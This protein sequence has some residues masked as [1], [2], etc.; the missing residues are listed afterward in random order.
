MNEIFTALQFAAQQDTPHFV[1]E[2]N[3]GRVTVVRP[4][5]ANFVPVAVVEGDRV[6][7]LGGSLPGLDDR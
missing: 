4:V 7:A 3:D 5:G 2:D 1:D 6:V